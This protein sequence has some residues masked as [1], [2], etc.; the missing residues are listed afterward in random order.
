MGY[1][2]YYRNSPWDMKNILWDIFVNPQKA[3]GTYRIAHGIFMLPM[4]SPWDTLNIPWDIYITQEKAH[5]THKIS[6]GISISS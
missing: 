2:S 4:K 1:F 6:H 5:G 3:H